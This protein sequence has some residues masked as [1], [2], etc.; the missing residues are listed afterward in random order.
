MRCDNKSNRPIDDVSLRDPRN[1]VVLHYPVGPPRHGN[2]ELNTDGR[3]IRK[4]QRDVRAQREPAP[5]A[6]G[7]T[8]PVDP[9]RLKRATNGDT[10]FVRP[11]HPKYLPSRFARD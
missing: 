6:G 2:R 8:H 4:Q 10:R 3:I 1:T 11:T 5:L 9:S 7:K